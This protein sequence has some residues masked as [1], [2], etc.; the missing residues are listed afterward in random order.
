MRRRLGPLTRLLVLE[1]TMRRFP[2]FW[3]SLAIPGL[4]AAADGP[5]RPL[6]VYVTAAQ[7]EARKDV[8]DATK[9]ALKAKREAAR[10][11]RKAA[12][13]RLKDELGKKRE[14]W[15][16]EK[17]DELYAL[18]EAEALARADYEYRKID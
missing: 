16:P 3:A 13:K 1:V 8:D 11:A 18:E 15:P 10:D 4:A 6:A 14:T 17:D 9:S 12:E 7:V 5:A 2:V